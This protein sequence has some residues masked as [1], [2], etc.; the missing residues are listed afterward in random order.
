MFWIVLLSIL[1]VMIVFLDGVIIAAFV[2]C[3]LFRKRYRTVFRKR[4]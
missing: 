4:P 3:R 1:A 2:Y